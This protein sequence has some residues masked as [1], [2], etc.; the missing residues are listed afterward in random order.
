VRFQSLTTRFAVATAVLVIV[1]LS[2]LTMLAITVGR[3]SVRREVQSGNATSAALAARAFEQYVLGCVSIVEEAAQRPKLSQEIRAAK[4]SE[5]A[6]V[7]EN[8]VQHF[9][10]FAYVFVQDT[11]GVIR[12]RVPYAKTVGQDFSFRDFFQEAVRTRQTYVSGVYVA[13]ATQQRVVTLAVPVPDG[14]GGLAGVL[15]AALSL[16]RM[17]EVLLELGQDRPSSLFVVDRQGILVGDSRGL[18][19]SEPVSLADRPVVQAVLAGRAGTMEIREPGTDHILLGAY[20]PIAR[21]GWGIVAVTPAAIAY[22]PVTRLA[23]GLAGIS[24]ACTVAALFV[25][26]VLTRRLTRPLRRLSEATA[27]VAGGDFQGAQVRVDG[28][29]EVAA[30]ATAF[31]R[32]AARIAV[33]HRALEDR[34][35]EVSAAH[36][37]LA[38]ELTERRRAELEVRRLNEE[39][40]QRVQE[41]TRELAAANGELEAFSYS[42]AHDLRAPLRAMDGFARILAEQWAPTLAPDAQ[43]LIGRV[44][45]NATQM[46]ALVDDLLA[47]SRL[48]RQALTR[49]PVAP[50]TLVREALDALHAEQEGRRVELTVDSL[51]LC[52]GDPALLKQV[53][54]NLLG[55]ALKFTRK[56][57]VAQIEVGCREDEGEWVYF[58]RDNGVGFDMR[59]AGKLFG[60]FQRQHRMEEYEGTGV[61]LAIVQRIVHRH[62]GRIWAEAALDAGATIFFT[63][64]G[65]GP[66]G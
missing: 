39:L 37:S 18:R 46:G 49:G 47:F 36:D 7:L 2:A 26:L 15:C 34:A 52:Q 22:A 5:A 19:T 62:G 59:Y 56:R 28:R 29:D 12:V 57:D 42:V 10:R 23:W 35:R 33:S 58:V 66:D 3:H 17:S 30:L 1:S 21:L 32:M 63:L 4:W 53:F 43:R 54:V 51:P 6:R 64:G 65:R 40:E 24:V 25:G 38:R 13:R 14:A 31:N 55:N 60:V 48:G 50:D 9:R 20:V 45:A 16:D 44:R 8:I 11:Q 61:G 41:R 27:Q